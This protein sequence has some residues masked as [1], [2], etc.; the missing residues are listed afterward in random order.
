[1]LGFT[2][3]VRDWNGLDK[4]IELIAMPGTRSPASAC[5]RR[6]SGSP[7]TEE[8]AQRAGVADRVTFTGVVPRKEVPSFVAAFDIALLPA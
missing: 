7:G 4:I 8:Q 1:V 5:G 6:R 3:F 2:G